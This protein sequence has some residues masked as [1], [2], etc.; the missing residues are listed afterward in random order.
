MAI[1]KHSPSLAQSKCEKESKG[2]DSEED[3]INVKKKILTEKIIMRNGGNGN[4][5][6]PLGD[7]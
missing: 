6:T 2:V 1:T 4:I 5:Q 3:L 7:A